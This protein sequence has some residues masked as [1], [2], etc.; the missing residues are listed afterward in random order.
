MILQNPRPRLTRLLFSLL[1]ALLLLTVSVGLISAQ[2]PTLTRLTIASADNRDSESPDLDAEGTAVVFHSDADFLGQGLPDNQFEIWLFD[3]AALTYTRLTTATAPNRDSFDPVLSDD[4]T[5]VAFRSNADFLNEGRPFVP[6]ELWLLDLETMAYTR[7][8][9]ASAKNRTSFAPTLS[10]DGRTVAFV[11]DS[12]FLDEGIGDNQF[13]IWLYGTETERLRR[14]TQATSAGVDSAAPALSADGRKLAFHS[15]GDFLDQG[16]STEQVEVWLADTETL[17]YSR[18]TTT[19]AGRESLAPSLNAAGSTIAFH[20]DFGF[21][22]QKIANNQF[23]I[24]LY[25]SQT[26]TYTR[27]TTASSFERVSFDPRLSADGSTITFMSDSDF[28][29]RGLRA[30]QLE[31]WLYDTTTMSYSRLSFATDIDRHSER[32]TINADGTSVAFE[33]NSD[34]L[35]EGDTSLQYHIWLYQAE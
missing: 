25:D 26:L 24:W 35:Q 23:E 19:T 6:P 27:I 28:L 17:T 5:V 12:D 30:G 21:S 34:F 16:I 3:T 20:S 18:I 31:V 29:K 11:S 9:S 22:G 10:A 4:G 32:P 2:R 1:V 33:S 7:I 15:N 14:V 13:E 8:T